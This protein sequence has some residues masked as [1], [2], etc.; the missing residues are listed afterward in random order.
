FYIKAHVPV[1][2][3][4][5]YEEFPQIENGVGMVADFLGRAGR[6]RKPAAVPPIRAT[7]VTGVS[8]SRI[9]K[10]TAVGLSG[11]RGLSLRLLTVRNRFFGD[12]VT[13]AGLL[14]G[15]D[16]AAALEGRR[17]GDLVVI[18]S[19]ALKEDD[20]MFLDG[21]SLKQLSCRFGVTMAPAG[22]FRNLVNLL[23]KGREG[24]TA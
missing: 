7:L 15:S 23:K 9:L 18:P 1:P 19:E 3:V 24:L 8:F 4:S 22:S 17:L 12:S 14:T 5:F 20:G 11:I 13:V 2:P 16:I 21:M 6:T 10:D